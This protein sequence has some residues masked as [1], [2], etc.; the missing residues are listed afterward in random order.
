MIT[1]LF[2]P[3]VGGS[4]SCVSDEVF[5]PIFCEIF[6]LAEAC[7]RNGSEM[8]GL[9]KGKILEN[10]QKRVSTAPI[11]RRQFEIFDDASTGCGGMETGTL[12]MKKSE[13]A[14]N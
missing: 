9:G 10:L 4:L 2:L 1:F 8:V 5:R 14:K 3:K 7:V 13:K 6:G 12:H 11:A